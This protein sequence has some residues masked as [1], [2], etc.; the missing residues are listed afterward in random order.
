MTQSSHSLKRGYAGNVECWSLA[1]IPDPDYNRERFP[2]LRLVEGYPFKPHP[3][4][5][6]QSVLGD[7][8]SPWK[9]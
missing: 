7:A 6:V 4:S 2:W 5:L 9:K 3:S 8:S 1:G